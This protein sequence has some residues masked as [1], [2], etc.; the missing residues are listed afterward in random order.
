MIN[1]NNYLQKISGG[2]G[3]SGQIESVD[4]VGIDGTVRAL[5]ATSIAIRRAQWGEAE[6]RNEEMTVTDA[7]ERLAYDLLGDAHPGW[8][9]NDGAYGSFTFDVAG[10]T[11]TL[12]CNLRFTASDLHTSTF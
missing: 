1:K 6:P 12:D 3:D 4:A 11:I 10:G 2:R 9:V 7:I 8:E 5:P